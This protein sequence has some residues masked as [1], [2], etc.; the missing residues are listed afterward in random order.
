VGG[1]KASPGSGRET[2][3]ERSAR[4]FA[5]VMSRFGGGSSSE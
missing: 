5:S 4:K 3:G 1:V 2:G